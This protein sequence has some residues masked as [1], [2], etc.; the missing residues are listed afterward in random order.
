MPID[1][2][3][4][5]RKLAEIDG[6]FKKSDKQSMFWKPGDTNT[7][8]IVPN[9]PQFY[10]ILKHY[11][12]A[13]VGTVICPTTFNKKCPLCELRI[14][15]YKNG[16]EEDRTFAKKLKSQWRFF[17]PVLVRGQKDQHEKPLWWEFSR[18]IYEQ[19]IMYCKNPE[20]GDISDPIKG[21]DLDVV[22][23]QPK[24]E[25]EFK[26]TNLSPKRSSSALMPNQEQ[27]DKVV[28]EVPDFMKDLKVMSYEE[29]SKIVDEWIAKKV[30]DDHGDLTTPEEGADEVFKAIDKA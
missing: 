19:I 11:Q 7:I 2:A 21:V 25:G 9:T 13:D 12:V 17:T 26:K 10:E 1:T 8:R 29:I 5:E 4:L 27:I 18:K 16:T 22:V 23:I 28:K 14:K 20:Y 3:E 6:K 30:D 24:K 15:L